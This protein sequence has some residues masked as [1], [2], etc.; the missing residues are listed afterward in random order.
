MIMREARC[1]CGRL[2]LRARGE[3]LRVSVCHCLDCQRRS[4][5]AFATQARFPAEA[6]EIAGEAREWSR[7][8]DEGGTSVHRFCPHCGSDVCY[9]VV[10][11]P[12]IVA[13]PVGA[14]ADPG[15]PPPSASVYEERKHAWVTITGEV[16]HYD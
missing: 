2:T 4:G 13:V 8:G 11:D 3:P 10:E 15:F 16:E 12:G 6:V 5:S 14:F 1:R 7:R 9:E